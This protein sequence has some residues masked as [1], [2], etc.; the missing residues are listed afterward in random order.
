MATCAVQVSGPTS[1]TPEVAV[2]EMRLAI[3]LNCAEADALKQILSCHG[4]VFD[5]F[6]RRQLRSVARK[7]TAARENARRKDTEAWRCFVWTLEDV[8][9]LRRGRGALDRRPS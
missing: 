3:S 6:E 8:I 1:P 7:A 2:D 4:A 9:I 5:K